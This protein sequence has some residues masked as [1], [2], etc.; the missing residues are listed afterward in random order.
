[1]HELYSAGSVVQNALIGMMAFYQSHLISF[2]TA[3]SCLHGPF[4]G[5][6]SEQQ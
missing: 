6:S 4:V 5:S 1:M 3:Y 2:A